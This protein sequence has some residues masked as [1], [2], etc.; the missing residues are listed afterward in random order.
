MRLTNLTVLDLFKNKK[1]L[2]FLIGA[3]CSVD[4]PANLPAGRKMMEKII[5]FS[6]AEEEIDNLLAIESLR[7]ESL[8]EII[9]NFLDSGL[10]IIDYYASCD[11]PNAQHFFFANML[12]KGNYIITTNFDLLIE[13]ALIKLKI[14]KKKIIPVITYNDFQQYSD[15]AKLMKDGFKP[16]YKIHGSP[17]NLITGENTKDSLITTIQA[18]GKGKEGTNIFQVEPFKRPLFNEIS[19]D[20]TL[21]VIGYS[22]SDD[23]DI[24]PTLKELKDLKRIIWFNYTKYPSEKIYEIDDANLK[25][26]NSK[27]KV[28][29]ILYDIKD[30]LDKVT[31]YKIDGNTSEI[32]KKL[33]KIS[34]K[35][36]EH[37]FNCKP[38][39]WFKNNLST[40]TRFQQHFIPIIIY[41][42]YGLMKEAINRLKHIS[43]IL[44]DNPK[45]EDLALYLFYLGMVQLDIGRFKKALKNFKT[46]AK[47]YH[48]LNVSMEANCFACI[49]EIH[50]TGKNIHTALNYY[51]KAL[52]ICE[53]E[54][55]DVNVK[56]IKADLHGKIGMINRHLGN[57]EA[58]M[59]HYKEGLKLAE[60]SGNLSKK[61]I[62]YN[63]IGVLI[64]QPNDI[65][66]INKAIKNYQ[67]ALKIAD[68]LGDYIL[69]IGA[70]N[71]LGK[72]YIY[73]NNFPHALELMQ[74]ASK[75][76]KMIKNPEMKCNIFTNIGLVYVLTNDYEK[77]LYYYNKSLEISEN[78]NLN[79]QKAR[80]LAEIAYVHYKQGN[81]I[82]V[83]EVIEQSLQIFRQIGMMNSPF[84]LEMK[85]FKV[86]LDK[87]EI[88][89]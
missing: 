87:E 16:V 65:N 50:Q 31:I 40:P 66:K 32:I 52:K 83:H 11:K 82:E 19:D 77:G 44:R 51:K 75:V 10:K 89:N 67:L 2:T 43:D 88:T 13:Y 45:T 63:N 81:D 8:V 86:L 25:D 56:C 29:K 74:Q 35:L 27:N 42:Q 49:G 9:N 24:V 15:P 53:R 12:I 69:K 76:A 26:F 22:G 79:L 14:P 4:S 59:I 48:K 17:V 60:D 84:A 37:A 5:R 78:H 1:D 3:G 7:F 36:N 28:D 57:F 38:I 71:N 33:S 18:L 73:L 61:G 58:A 55:D 68:N 30:K 54:R 72:A 62:I 70:L 20:R 34:P 21:V 80:T 41:Y 39:S 6:C 23:F 46:A 47:M 85:K 64:I